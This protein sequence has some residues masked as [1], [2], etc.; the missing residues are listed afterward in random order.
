[1]G[2]LQLPMGP[3]GRQLS[4]GDLAVYRERAWQAARVQMN[5]F[6]AVIAHPSSGFSGQ[7][8]R[9][10]LAALYEMDLVLLDAIKACE[11]GDERGNRR[12]EAIIEEYRLARFATV[13]EA[14][15]GSMTSGDT[16]MDYARDARTA[17]EHILGRER[18]NTAWSAY[19]QDNTVP[20]VLAGS[21]ADRRIVALQNARRYESP[22]RPTWTPWGRYTRTT[23]RR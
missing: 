13:P 18:E 11:K 9:A 12:A 4:P 3:V 2:F 10:A 14:F 5:A 15:S 7:Q 16:L 20:M 6:R 17:R 21:E 22:P 19:V 1:M 8:R 23:P